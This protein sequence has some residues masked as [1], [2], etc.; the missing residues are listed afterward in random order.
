[1]DAPLRIEMLG[2]LRVQ[3]GG[4][5]LTRFR[6]HKTG[7]L[8]AYLAFH[9]GRLQ[10]REVLQELLWAEDEPKRARNNL[11]IALTSLRR[12]LEPPGTP[13]STV[14]EASRFNVGLNRAAI[15]TDVAEFESALKAARGASRG[16]LEDRS[17]RRVSPAEAQ[18]LS[19]AVALYRGPLLPGF[20]EEWV[21][22]E[23]ER[24][25]D[26]FVVA[27]RDLA[28]RL[29]DA[30]DIA[31]A[32]DCARRAVSADPLREEAHLQLM[33]LYVTAGEPSAAL[34][35]FRELERALGEELG[36]HPTAEAVHLAQAI[37][38]G[39]SLPPRPAAPAPR[40]G[41]ARTDAP[42]APLCPTTEGD[43]PAASPS[44][45]PGQQPP[46]IRLPL[47]LT[48]F[49][50]REEEITR[51]ATLLAP[52]QFA[53][54]ETQG[55]QGP[56]PDAP[57][58]AR[59]PTRR[60]EG[61]RL[62]TLTGPGGCG[63]TRLAIEVARQVADAMPGGVWF[64]PLADLTDP[65]LI[66]GAIVD[67]LRLPRAPDVDAMDQVAEWLSDHSPATLLLLLDNFEHLLADERRKSEDGAAVLR[68]LLERL[69]SLRVLVT[70][71]RSLNL[72][73][74]REFPVQPLPVPASAVP[75]PEEL[76]RYP[77]VK[78]FVDRAQAVRPDFQV[79]TRNAADIAALCSGLEGLPLAIELAAAR[80]QVMTPAQ[81]LA[82]LAH[83]LDF[84]V[85][86][87]RDASERHRTLKAALDWSVRLLS[88]ELRRFYGQ[89]S[90]LRGGWTL[91][92]ASAIADCAGTRVIRNRCPGPPR[93]TAGV[94]AHPGRG[95]AAGDA[96]PDAGNG[97]RV[98]LGAPGSHGT[99]GGTPAACGVLSQPR[100]G[101][102]A[103]SIRRGAEDLA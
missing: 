9:L 85:S 27:A 74:E 83:R 66:P 65:R 34:R 19:R 76:M 26:M 67:A 91:E 92:A 53:E 103:E 93:S 77:G 71:R 60:E 90:V 8:L 82:Q 88:P 11:S 14:L 43:V 73:G 58:L 10:P 89:L 16:A 15:V 79:T 59:V 25:A 70:S 39:K 7:A 24:L 94:L 75:S 29:L 42:G 101:R 22:A 95:D 55:S 100:T 5:E 72:E 32:F 86:R 54:R 17:G 63:M 97:A 64:V 48:R 38:A 37:A 6:T 81:M 31:G 36:Q 41:A 4:R 80:A 98:R 69:P 12:Q 57:R 68:A 61:V 99:G 46:T 84:L 56:A 2:G 1:M 62:L 87:R 44:A 33:R 20:Y 3:Q 102:V 40:A 18:H 47:Q 78:L 45:L 30:G 51:L 52:A 50:G 13:T 28:A 96:I 23:Q 49:F 21:P 35:Q